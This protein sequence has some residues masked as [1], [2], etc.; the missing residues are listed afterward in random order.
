MDDLNINKPW[1]ELKYGVKDRDDYIVI[2][3]RQNQMI[4]ATTEDE[5]PEQQQQ[6]TIV[7]KLWSTFKCHNFTNG[8]IVVGFRGRR[9]YKDGACQGILCSAW[10]PENNHF[11]PHPYTISNGYNSTF[12]VR[13]FNT[14]ECC[15]ADEFILK[16]PHA[17]K[18]IKKQF[19]K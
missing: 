12:N 19:R 4:R 14:L 8:A 11:V 6:S 16:N 3:R 1:I 9:D 5:Q 17:I 10:S 7:L 13:D 15:N 18:N 2:E